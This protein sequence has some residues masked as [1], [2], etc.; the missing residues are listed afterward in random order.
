MA[1]SRLFCS[2]KCS[3]CR[4]RESLNLR[5]LAFRLCGLVFKCSPNEICFMGDNTIETR[6]VG[7]HSTLAYTGGKTKLI[8][9]NGGR[10][11]KDAITNGHCA[12]CVFIRH[13]ALRCAEGW[14]RCRNKRFTWQ[15]RRIPPASPLR[16]Y[17]RP[18][19]LGLMRVTI[20]AL[21]AL[22]LITILAT[23]PYEGAEYD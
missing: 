11:S 1:L 12:V 7:S 17:C 22:I 18:T 23:T 13:T 19:S 3:K 9:Q 21:R 2:R 20:S 5:W 16:G 6:Q 10:H 4:M 8:L 15:S 14:R